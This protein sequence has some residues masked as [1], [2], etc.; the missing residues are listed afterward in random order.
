M[1]EISE[2]YFRTGQYLHCYNQ[3]NC[4]KIMIFVSML[5]PEWSTWCLRFAWIFLQLKNEARN[6]PVETINAKLLNVAVSSWLASVITSSAWLIPEA[7]NNLK[8][9]YLKENL[10]EC[11][12]AAK[13]TC[14]PLPSVL[15]DTAFETMRRQ[16]GKYLQR[17]K[18]GAQIVWT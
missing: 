17:Q 1:R 4:C 9:L 15:R 3:D 16:L 14:G 10:A 11:E 12:N 8:R 6:K 18:R 2:I 7:R 13:Y 5:F